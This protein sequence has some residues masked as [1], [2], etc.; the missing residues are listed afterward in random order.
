M[1]EGDI[2]Q[3]VPV[4]EGTS[5][6]T[7]ADPTIGR[8][9]DGSQPAPSTSRARRTSFVDYVP[10]PPRPLPPAKYKLWLLVLLCVFFADWFAYEAG[11]FPWLQNT[12]KLSVN[13]ALLILLACVVCIIIY[14]G[15]DLLVG[16]VK[17]KIHGEWYGIGPWLKQ[18]RIQWV[19][20][21]QNCVVE[22]IRSIVVIF[23]DG[24]AIF[25][26]PKTNESTE[27][28]QFDDK[29][30]HDVVLK[31]ENRIHPDKI[32]EYVRWRD[33]VI[34]LG[35]HARPGL[36]KVE[37]E[38]IQDPKGGLHVTYFTFDSIDHLNEYMTSPVR[39]RIVRNLEPLLATP[40]LVQL[41][42]D[43]QLP[44]V[45]SDL[46]T[47]QS[48]SVPARPPKKWRV[49]FITT[50]SKCL[51]WTTTTLHV[52]DELSGE[53]VNLHHSSSYLQ[54]SGSLH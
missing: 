41:Q 8:G 51:W 43:R 25:D 7:T 6:E 36:K 23:E 34:Q 26:V 19:H 1:T 5:T 30:G 39:T 24:F 44:D 53:C 18:P 16:I 20:Q 15:F 49:W 27:P 52:I 10:P 12:F 48:Q 31:I 11:F 40:S 46:C 17:I 4:M 9:E 42:K 22:F 37:E 14:A 54:V 32:E 47:E 3:G 13:G 35:C 50:L 33:N 28:K 2:E 21:Y 45:F 38:V 29:D